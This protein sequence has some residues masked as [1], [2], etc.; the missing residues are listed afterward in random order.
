M[1]GDGSGDR[2]VVCAAVHGLTW[3]ALANAIGVLMAVLL[4][5]PDAGVALVPVTYGRWMPVHLN[6]ALYGWCA[7]PMVGMLL[8]LYRPRPA[9]LGEAAVQLWSGA[10]VVGAVAWASGITTGK[11]FLDWAG[12]ARALFIGALVALGLVL[13]TGLVGHAR[14]SDRARLF[15][16]TT[17]WA[18]LMLVPLAILVTSRRAVYPPINPATGGPTGASLLGSTLLVVWIVALVPTLLRLPCSAGPWRARVTFLAL[19]AHTLVFLVLDHGD[20]SHRDPLASAAVATLVVWA[21]LLPRHLG[22][23]AWPAAS[24][25]WRRA[26]YAWG[27]VLVG[28]AVVSFLPGVLDAM[29][30]TN[31]LV[32]HAHLAMAG[33]ATSF[34]AMLLIALAPG[35]MARALGGR[36][37]F[38]AWHLGAVVHVVAMTAAGAREIALPG[39][40]F[41]ADGWI[42]GLYAARAAGGA[43]MLG[44]SLVWL[45]RALARGDA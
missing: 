37:A 33:M 45:T 25:R 30:F 15:G 16:L 8:A 42:T 43:A 10:L 13:L 23:F 24:V 21:W 3:L 2:A 35:A 38:A 29:K 22:S 18:L 12:G 36:G 27:G 40:T 9:V 19:A 7:L 41:R 14:E 32:A 4:L 39:I 44:A 34:A 26:F 20:R 28:S 6:L 17:L 31:V 1:S 11:P 5:A